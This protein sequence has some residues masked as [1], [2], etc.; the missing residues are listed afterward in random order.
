MKD[1]EL[2]KTMLDWPKSQQVSNNTKPGGGSICYKFDLTRHCRPFLDNRASSKKHMAK[3]H[4]TGNLCGKAAICQ[5]SAQMFKQ[6]V[7]LRN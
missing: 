3:L 6:V 2:R 5:N 1:F 7:Q 4:K